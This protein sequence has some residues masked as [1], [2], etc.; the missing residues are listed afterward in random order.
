MAVQSVSERTNSPRL[1]RWVITSLGV[2]VVLIIGLV[3]WTLYQNTYDIREE[4]VTI[5]GGLVPLQGVLALPDHGD[6]PFGLVVFVHGDGPI[7]ATHE[8]FYRP[9][10]ESFAQ[11][12]YAS[13][14]WD[15]PGVNGAPGNWLGQS[16][17]DRAAETE[18]AIEWARGRSDIDPARIG[19]WGASQAG[20][21]MPKVVNLDSDIAFVIAV[22]PAVNWL[23]QGEFNTRAELSERN[24]SADAFEKARADRVKSL[25]QL[26]RDASFD[27]LVV[28]GEADGLTEDR[29][30]FIRKN[31]RSDA[32]A[33]LE[34]VDVPVLLILG[35]HDVN[36]D[37]ADTESVYRELL[38]SPGQLVVK[39]YPEAT[40][41]LVEKNLEDSELMSTL[42]AVLAPRS[43]FAPGY[44]A[45]QAAFLA[46][47]QG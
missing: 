32:R 7:D 34:T 5:T 11:A 41:S 33:D 45:D 20:W 21:V 19:L 25:E 16:M 15:K 17:D 12:G 14:S 43:L 31:Y 13:L 1:R 47:I 10:W 4:K 35:G 46:G 18:A 29:W 38:D 27:D 22:S 6:G 28:S 39:K 3:G 40:H 9:L 26:A 2:V 8:T 36:V 24:A 37:V 44:L 42:V 30:N 23:E